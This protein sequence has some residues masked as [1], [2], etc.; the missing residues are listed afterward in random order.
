MTGTD[1]GSRK[2]SLY[3]TVDSF[4]GALAVGRGLAKQPD[5][6]DPSFGWAHRGFL[7]VF[8]ESKPR[9]TVF[10]SICT[11]PRHQDVGIRRTIEPAQ[12]VLGEDP[13]GKGHITKSPQGDREVTFHKVV[14]T[15]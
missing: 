7:G 14:I 15:A 5:A 11:T 1:V 10:A 12:M 8:T 2:D 6:E 4:G 3:R 13:T 9:T